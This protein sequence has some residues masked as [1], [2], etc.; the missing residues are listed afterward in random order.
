MAAGFQAKEGYGMVNIKIL[1]SVALVAVCVLLASVSAGA[2]GVTT[3]SPGGP[4]FVGRTDASCPTFSWAVEGSADAVE[5]VVYRVGA[6]GL[7]SQ[8][9]VQET[10]PGKATTWT[11]SL[12][13][14][15]ERGRQYAWSIRSL[16][17]ETESEWSAPS[18]FKVVMTSTR[19]EFE[20]AL[21]IVRQYLATHPVEEEEEV[22]AGGGLGQ[23]APTTTIGNDPAATAPTASTQFSVTNGDIALIDPDDN[24]R[25]YIQLDTVGTS[26]GVFT[27]P[28]AA[29]CDEVNEYGRMMFDPSGFGNGGYLF[30]CDDTG[31][32]NEHFS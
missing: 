21:R 19:A 12:G 5:L 16:G 8:P 24:K 32:R 9:V 22:F 26:G 1:K 30:I 29:D 13:G 11:P 31:W 17:G 20:Q 25:L 14:C 18:F 2:Q 27:L 7:E 15:F 3:V 4:E 10:L 23:T 6:M 28:P